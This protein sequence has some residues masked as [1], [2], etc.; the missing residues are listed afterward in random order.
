ML[1]QTYAGIEAAERLYFGN[2][3]FYWQTG[4]LRV[5]LLATTSC[6]NLLAMLDLVLTAGLLGQMFSGKG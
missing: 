3:I 2:V 6:L 5:S 4:R 1:G